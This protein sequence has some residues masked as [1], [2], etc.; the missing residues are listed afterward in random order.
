M[1]AAGVHR[2]ILSGEESVVVITR[3]DAFG[4]FVFDVHLEIREDGV[5]REEQRKCTKRQEK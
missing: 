4:F 5:G 3:A 2:L 1:F